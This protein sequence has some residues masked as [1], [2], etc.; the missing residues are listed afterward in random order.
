MRNLKNKKESKNNNLKEILILK[1]MNGVF[2]SKN[3]I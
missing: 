1:Y 2:K 3:H